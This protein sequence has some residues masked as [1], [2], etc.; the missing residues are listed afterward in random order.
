MAH[1][2]GIMHAGARVIAEVSLNEIPENKDI[3]PAGFKEVHQRPTA[4]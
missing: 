2:K 4:T 3:R 1:C